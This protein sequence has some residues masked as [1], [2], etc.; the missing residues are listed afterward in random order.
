MEKYLWGGLNRVKVSHKCTDFLFGKR[1]VEPKVYV[2]E[3]DDGW[4][5][6]EKMQKYERKK[7]N[8]F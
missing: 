5:S 2:Q 8:F 4:V 6:N 3:F 1:G 7:H